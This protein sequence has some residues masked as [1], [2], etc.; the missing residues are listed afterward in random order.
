[1]TYGTRIAFEDIREVAFGSITANYTAV[2]SPT[3]DYGRLVGITNNT[4]AEVYISIDGTNDHLRL[5]ANS[6][7]LLDLTTNG[8]C[9]GLFLAKNISFYIKR[10]SGAP[11]SGDVW[12]EVLYGAGGK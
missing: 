6:F 8:V 12:I 9:A 3:A 5:A 1:M 10:V 2:G 11:T 4:D 7:K